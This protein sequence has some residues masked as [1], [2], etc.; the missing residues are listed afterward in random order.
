MRWLSKLVVVFGLMAAGTAS[1]ALQQGKDYK[2]MDRPQPVSQPGKL[3]VIEFFWYACP[4]CNSINPAV[5]AWAGK[6]PKDVNFRRVHINWEDP[7]KQGHVKLFLTLQA[8]GLDTKLQ[9][10]VFKAI[11][12][13]KLELRKEDVLYAWLKTQQVDVEKFK[14]IYNGFSM[15]VMQSNLAKMTRDYGVDGVPRFVVNGRYIA[16]PANASEESS[17]LQTVDALLAAGRAK[18]GKKK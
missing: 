11:F 1:A 3:E 17:V 14:A 7:S 6:L 8:M 18:V 4:H 16:L 10:A 13:D 15:G 2:L 5:E 12:Q 9:P